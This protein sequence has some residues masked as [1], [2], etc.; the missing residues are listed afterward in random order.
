[1]FE[2]IHIRIH[3]TI[4][5][6]V[7]LDTEFRWRDEVFDPKGA[8]TSKQLHYEQVCRIMNRGGVL[9]IGIMLANE[10]FKIVPPKIF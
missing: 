4:M 6:V 10:L 7:G 9:Q 5:L 8:S 1:M 2:K 3:R